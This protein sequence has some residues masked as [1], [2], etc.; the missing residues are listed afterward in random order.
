MLE[1]LFVEVYTKFKME[2]Y[3]KIFGRFQEREASLTAT[4]TFCVEVIY[5]LKRPTV[6]QFADFVEISGPNAAYKVNNLIKKGYI[7]KIQST[8]DRREFYLEVTDK[9]MDYYNITSDYISTVVGRM[10]DY[11]SPDEITTLEKV[12]YV[13]TSE[14][15]PEVSLPKE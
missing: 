7:N 10:K 6:K 14:L 5:G 2:F 4:E 12:L 8:E 13:M 3:K 15:M 11:F 1:A 9:Y